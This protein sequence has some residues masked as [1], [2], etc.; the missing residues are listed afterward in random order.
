MS[1]HKMLELILSN[2]EEMKADVKETKDEVKKI[3]GRVGKLE[4]DRASKSSVGELKDRVAGL[5]AD[6][7]WRSKIFDWVLAGGL[8]VIGILLKAGYDWLQTN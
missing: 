2:Q 8:I 3:N 6:D 7:K 5:E 1:D 4:N